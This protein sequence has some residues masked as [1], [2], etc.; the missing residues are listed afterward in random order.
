MFRPPRPLIVPIAGMALATLSFT[1][2]EADE[3]VTGQASV[4][5]GDTVEIGGQRIDL[6]GID[7]PEAEQ[8][9]EDW[10]G[11]SYRCGQHAAFALEGYI[12]D[13]PVACR[14]GVEEGWEGAV[15]TVEGEDLGAWMVLRGWAFAY[16]RDAVGYLAQEGQARERRAG[17]W[18]GGFIYPWQ[19]RAAN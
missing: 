14:P 5:D 1:M 7:A 2:A 12:A 11:A 13:R 18:S 6:F 15:C 9:C 10:S 4:I 8:E 19:W 3:P 17:L 16:P